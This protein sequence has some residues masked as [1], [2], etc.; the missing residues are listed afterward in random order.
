MTVERGCR[1]RRYP[2]LPLLL[3]AGLIVTGC[4]K[5]EK[6]HDTT[7]FTD[8]NKGAI[9]WAS[10]PA[11]KLVRQGVLAAE[12]LNGIEA[13][14]ALRIEDK[15][16]EVSMRVSAQLV[17]V[18]DDRLRIS[19]TKMVGDVM[20]LAMVGDD[21]DIYLPSKKILYRGAVHDLS[22]A[23]LNF[24]PQEIV[25]QLLFPVRRFASADWRIV[26]RE[27]GATVVEADAGRRTRLTIGNAQGE[28]L[29]Q[30][31]MDKNGRVWLSV[32][33]GEHQV[34]EG[35]NGGLYPHKIEMTFP[36]EE[37]YLLIS[38]RKLLPN[39]EAGTSDFWL[40]VP[41][42]PDVVVKPFKKHLA[43]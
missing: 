28:L 19:A 32:A 33:Y 23:S 9:T 10:T 41:T 12:N 20:D 1:L 31:I 16:E 6:I 39:P 3:L 4:K 30:E 7:S 17:A 37:R 8:L 42:G 22:G 25:E 36:G 34:I 40:I 29:K 11:A 18:R 27:P 43:G 14:V 15:K 26:R 13:Q 24:H 35:G 38:I 2:R 21:L 5:A